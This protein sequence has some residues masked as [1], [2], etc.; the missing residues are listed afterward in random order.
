MNCS[1]KRGESDL[2]SL[3]EAM[4]ET[5]GTFE[6]PDLYD[7]IVTAQHSA[8]LAVTRAEAADRARVL[9]FRELVLQRQEGAERARRVALRN[10]SALK[11][12]VVQRRESDEWLERIRRLE[13]NERPTPLSELLDDFSAEARDHLL[14]RDALPAAEAGE[15]MEMLTRMVER[16][17]QGVIACID[18]VIETIES[19]SEILSRET[20]GR[21]PASPQA[22]A[23]VAC[24]AAATAAL[25]AA[26]TGC[27]FVPFCWCCFFPALLIAYILAVDACNSIPH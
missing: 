25:I 18:Q 27:G 5:L 24:T 2:V 3:R 14:N 12:Y 23:Y 7:R 11:A 16:G 22:A 17:K 19:A 1:C 21:E 9:G 6:L 13:S 10:Y 26:T 4:H 8:T 20:F 15:Q